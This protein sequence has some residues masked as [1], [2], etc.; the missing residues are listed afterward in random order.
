M[1]YYTYEL[2]HALLGPM[3]TQSRLMRRIFGNPFSPL[4]YTPMGRSI[5]ASC[6]VFESVT[7]RYGKP[8][9]GF[10]QTLMGGLARAHERGGGLQPPFCDLRHFDR[11]ERVSG[12]RYDPK[13]LL[14]APMSGHY[15]TLLRGT[16]QAMLPEHNLYIT[17]WRGRA[18][19][20]RLALGTFDLDDFIDY[21]I[22]FL[23]FIGTNTHVIAVCQPA[24]PALAAAALMA[25]LERSRPAGLAD[26]DGR[27]DRHPAQPD[28]REQARPVAQP[29]E[30]FERNVI[31]Y[32]PC[33][34][35]GFMRRVY[36]GFIQLTGFM[37]MNLERHLEA[38]KSL[39]NHLVKGDCDSGG[40]AS[41]RSTTNTWP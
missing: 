5:A 25:A 41:V 9:C 2:T 38:H 21:L 19:A 11:D 20:C 34:N 26:A 6:E 32:V 31:A 8:E 40:A 12:K 3:H 15:A 24:V 28:G 30:W 1:H 33:P 39:F 14:V 7:R 10:E 18:R 27:A 17:D 35:P 4:A 13:V 36:P 16:V 23:H 37:K 22:D 29:I